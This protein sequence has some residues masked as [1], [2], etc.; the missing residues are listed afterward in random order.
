MTMLQWGYTASLQPR[1]LSWFLSNHHQ[2]HRGSL[3]KSILRRTEAHFQQ[4]L[5]GIT[6]APQIQ[7]TF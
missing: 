4:L 5:K 7:F 1:G 3:S 6:L 2:M